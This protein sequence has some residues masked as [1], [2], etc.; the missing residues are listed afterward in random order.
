MVG[1]ISQGPGPSGISRVMIFIDGGY[2]RKELKA[3]FGDDSLNY[4]KLVDSLRNGTAY[5]PLFPQLVRWYYYDGIP[6]P[7]EVDKYSRQVDYLQRI[8]DN[9]FAEVRLGRVKQDAE[10]LPR[11]KGVD[12]LIAIDMLSKAYED[13]YDIAVL[14]AGDDD[15]LDLVKAVKNA[16]KQIYGAFFLG[17]VSTDLQNEFDRRLFLKKDNVAEMRKLL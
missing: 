5:G 9:D 2:L 7:K 4:S 12:T 16:G 8:R 10:G 3:L 6:D 1:S 15:F 14:L 17:H 11:Q 13:H